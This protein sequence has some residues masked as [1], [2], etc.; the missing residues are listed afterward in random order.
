MKVGDTV[1]I[2]D[3]G[4]YKG[5]YQVPVPCEGVLIEITDYPTY[6]VEVDGKKFEL[7]DYQLKPE[8]YE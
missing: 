2:Y 6:W 8:D 7:Y 1:T 4:N 5:E 3:M